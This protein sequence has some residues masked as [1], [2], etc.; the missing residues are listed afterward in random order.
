MRQIGQGILLYCNDNK[1]PYPPDLG[2]LIKTEDLTAGVFL[3]PTVGKTPPNLTPDQ[4]VDWVNK[5]SD[6]VY[7]G[8]GL[9]MGA[10]P[11]LVVLYEKDDD[12]KGDGMNILYADGHVEFQTLANAHQEIEQ[13]LA[14]RKAANP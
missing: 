12:H 2:T 7:I 5:N 1:G 3:C 10:D 9:K 8:A 14:A 4:Y 6:Y 13:T 11:A